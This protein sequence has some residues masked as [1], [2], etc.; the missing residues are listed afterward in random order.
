LPDASHVPVDSQ[1]FEIPGGFTG[2]DVLLLE[3]PAND[4]DFDT[5]RA[6]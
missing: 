2:A 5:L 6:P 3:E 1:A 4:F